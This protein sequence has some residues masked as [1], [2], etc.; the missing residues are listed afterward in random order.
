MANGFGSDRILTAIFTATCD[1]RPNFG[2][3]RGRPPLRRGRSRY[4]GFIWF[5]R[6]TVV[7]LTQW[8]LKFDRSQT[9]WFAGAK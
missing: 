7:F 9:Q 8:K 4:K 5:I 3:F 6:G 1:Q 2:R